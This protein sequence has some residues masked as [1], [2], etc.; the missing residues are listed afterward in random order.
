MIRVIL[1]K[2]RPGYLLLSPDVAKMPIY[3]P[4]TKLDD[5][6]EDITSQ[7]ALADFKQALIEFLPN[8][9]TTLM[10]DLMVH[11]LGLQNQLKALIADTD[12]PY[13]TLS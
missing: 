9:T 13:T 7:A 12:I 1:K 4:T 2:H 8:K 11:R 6:Q 3:P 5:S 10:A